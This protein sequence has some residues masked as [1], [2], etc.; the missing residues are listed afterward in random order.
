[1]L[2]PY[3][4][5]IKKYGIRP[6]GILHLGANDG[7]ELDWYIQ[8]GAENIVFVEALPS[9]FEKLEQ[10]CNYHSNVKDLYIRCINA[11]LSNVEG[12]EVIF[13]ISSN[14]GE[15]S[16]MFEF[17]LHKNIHPDVF[18]IDQAKLKTKRWDC[19]YE[20]Q[21]NYDLRMIDFDFLNVDLQG[22]ELIALKGMGDCLREFKWAYIEVNRQETYRGCPLVEEIDY[23]MAKFGFIR[24]ETHP[25]VGGMW[26]DAFYTKLV[27]S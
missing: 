13:N 20:E 26:S 3:P 9:V 12:D 5:L 23:Y 6:N 19:I 10:R 7:A 2:I 14:N 17:G 24:I 18:Y 22:A 15:S 25:W 1:M 27:V 8:G 4:Q 21:D 16:S 11:C